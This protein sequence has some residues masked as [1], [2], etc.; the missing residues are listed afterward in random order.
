MTRMFA[1]AQS[2]NS[3]ISKWETPNVKNRYNMFVNCPL[4]DEHRPKFGIP[5]PVREGAQV[6]FD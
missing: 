4:P 3:D 2:F 5:E 6:V 1:G